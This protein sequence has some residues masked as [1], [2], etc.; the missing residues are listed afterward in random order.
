MTDAETAKSV[1]LSLT[2]TVGARLR[3]DDAYI[4][5]VAVSIVDYNFNHSSK[6][7][8]LHSATDITRHIYDAACILF[9]E[10]WNHEPIRQLGVHTSKA[11]KNSMYQYSLF[12]EH[13]A[14]KLQN[15]DSAI[16]QIRE[17]YGEDAIK[18]ACF[19][20]SKQEHMA[21][22]LDKAKRTGITK[23]LCGSQFTDFFHSLKN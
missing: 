15:L 17:R 14:D 3:A 21:G 6:Q 8:T 9:D 12:D 11:I 16:D 2:E 4:S 7:M 22:G 5:V 20:N 19:I 13:D 1:L 23:E 18:R 10:L